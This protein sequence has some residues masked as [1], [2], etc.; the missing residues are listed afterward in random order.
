[1][2]QK[3]SGVFT[4]MLLIFIGT[5][6]FA[7]EERYLQV[8]VFAATAEQ[9]SRLHNFH[10]DIIKYAKEYVEIITPI[11]KF[12]ELQALG[13]KTDI[14][15]EDLTGFYRSRLPDKAMGGYKTLAEIDSSVLSI[16]N[17]HPGLVSEKLVIGQS[18]EGRD[19]WAIK[20]SDNPA[21]DE[22]EPE[23][24][25]T[26][27][28]HARE[29]ITPE[30]LLHFMD[31]LTNNYETD[32]DVR[33]LVDNRELWFVPIVNPD[34]YAYN[35]TV[36]PEGGGLW[37]K[38]RRDNGDGSHGVD[39]N[40]N[41]GYM[42]GYDDI[43]SSPNSENETY[44]GTGPFSEPET[45]AL[46]DFISSQDFIIAVH[47]HSFSDLILWP[48]GYKPGLYTPDE[49]IFS[50]IGERLEAETGYF[51]GPGWT[52]YPTNGDANDWGYAEQTVKE[53]IYSFAIE[54]GS[55]EDGFWPEP[56]RI[57]EL[58]AENLP[59][60]LYLA[61]IADNIHAA[62]R[63]ER[64]VLTAPELV[65]T[66]MPYQ[67]AWSH[68]DTL[69]PAVCYELVEMQGYRVVTDSADDFDS[70]YNRN[71]LFELSNNGHSFLYSFHSGPPNTASRYLQ[72][73]APYAVQPGDTLHFWTTYGIYHEW[74]YAY[75]EVSTD[76]IDFNPIA[77]NLTTTADAYG[78][79]RGHG[80]TGEAFWWIEA[81]FDLANFVGD[82]IYLRFSYRD[83]N[84]DRA[85]WG[86]FID[87]ISPVALFDTVSIISSCLN[88][89]SYQLAGKPE[90]TYYYKVRARDADN[91]W[92]YYSPLRTVTVGDLPQPVCGDVT[93]DADINMLDI[94][95]I[96]D[97]L[98]SVPPGPAPEPPKIG[99]VNDDES[100][101]LLDILFLISYLYKNPP[102]PEP[103]CR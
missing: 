9:I 66:G 4:L 6:I 36:A 90:G 100:L 82:S 34:G 70:W 8:R 46:R 79:N 3:L 60:C 92:G 81:W 101:N 5:T 38:N 22:D 84:L 30:I 31:Y 65:A 1:M 94:L 64:P 42:W 26:A 86:I 16:I 56:S 62:L 41:F 10:P 91:Q 40:R 39:L 98:Y 87:D 59:G 49:H 55:S 73:M 24:L 83:H 71:S 28:I 68:N 45:Q 67:L 18:L 35:E 88:D 23:V 77:G 29:V 103:V 47:F 63:P 78:H 37:R 32:P 15:H 19:I 61:R 52:F 53:R 44:R 48:Y 96:V 57:P 50:A 102:G 97:H 76:G 33:L 12:E 13:F 17:D 58:V 74:D 85:W 2:R 72:T 89:T 99:D 95:F 11:G 80:I 54:V 93:G 51:P 7:A 43:G 21:V 14:V 69:N 25:Y 20:I 75:V 27:A